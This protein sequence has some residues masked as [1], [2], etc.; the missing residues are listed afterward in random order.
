MRWFNVYVDGKLD[1]RLGKKFKSGEDEVTWLTA[2]LADLRAEESEE[3]V[4]RYPPTTAIKILES[5]EPGRSPVEIL[6]DF[7]VHREA[8][9][10]IGLVE[11]EKRLAAEVIL[12]RGR[13]PRG[14]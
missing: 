14:V 2:R 11:E 4:P 10:R 13:I 1:R 7:E 5:D 8:A 12:R 3:G 9:A 6:L